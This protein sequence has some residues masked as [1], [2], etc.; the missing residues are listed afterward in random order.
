MS[1]L[2]KPPWRGQHD[3]A[4]RPDCALSRADGTF[5]QHRVEPAVTS[6]DVILG[7][8]RFKLS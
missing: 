1:A 8:H 3:R 4:A 7:T 2:L 5:G 6:A